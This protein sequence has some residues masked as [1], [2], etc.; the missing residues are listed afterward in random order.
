MDKYYLGFDTTR[1]NSTFSSL[2]KMNITKALDKKNISYTFTPDSKCSYAIFPSA[3][4]YFVL[5]NGVSKRTKV[6][7]LALNDTV[8]LFV[9]KTQELQLSQDAFSLYPL[10]DDL[11]IYSRWQK[12]F[13]ALNGLEDKALLVQPSITFDSDNICEAD[14]NAF[15][16]FFRI[17][18]ERMLILSY[19]SYSNKKECQTLETIARL[20]PDKAF[21]FF[22]HNDRAFVKIKTAERTGISDNIYYLDSLPG[23]LYHS[24]LLSTD[25]LLFTTRYLSFPSMIFDFM[26]H[27]V[28]IIAYKPLNFNDILTTNT[29]LLPNDFPSLYKA[30]QDIKKINKA[31]E[32]KK[33]VYSLL[34]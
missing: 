33:F 17:P 5:R 8:D 7:I 18:K 31:K 4:D 3:Q 32:A 10:V 27:E 15:R 20:N 16:S 13:L 2:I 11:I 29:C 6:G 19:G 25:L 34:D 14:K 24:A 30:I 26:A 21:L 9:N 12:K 28:P 23:E 22:G 1:L